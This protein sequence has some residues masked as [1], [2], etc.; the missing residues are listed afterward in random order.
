MRYLYN[1]TG[2]SSIATDVDQLDA[3][4]D[5]G[6]GDV[7]EFKESSS[8]VTTMDQDEHSVTVAPPADPGND[9]D[10]VI[11]SHIPEFLFQVQIIM[12]SLSDMK[13]AFMC[14]CMYVSM[15]VCM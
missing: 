11:L 4:I 5:E 9:E 6:F 14:A 3:Q 7:N 1:Q 13:D 2:R 12:N 15:F 8:A 10:E